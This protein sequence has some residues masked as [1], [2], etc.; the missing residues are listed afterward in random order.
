[1]HSGTR[2]FSKDK[3]RLPEKGADLTKYR[4]TKEFQCFEVTPRTGKNIKYPGH[5]RCA[6]E[7]AG[8]LH[9]GRLPEKG[10]DLTQCR[11]NQEFQCFEV[12]PR[13]G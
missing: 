13:T 3:G 8:F 9:K 6:H 11:D 12:T 5:Q 1:M 4:N 10:A 2:R 7:S